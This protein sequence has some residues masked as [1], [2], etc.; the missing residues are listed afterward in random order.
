MA[1]KTL[2]NAAGSSRRNNFDF[3]RFAAASFV[4]ISHSFALAGSY[5]EPKIGTT[6]LGTLGVN[7]FFIISGYLI[8][9]SWE[10]HPRVSA[11]IGKRLLRIVP[12][13]VGATLFV[14]LI[15]GPIFT[16]L[17][18]DQYFKHQSTTSYLGNIS[19]FTLQYHLPGVW[20]NNAF[21][22]NTNGPLWTLP[23]EFVA[24]LC[25]AIGGFVGILKNRF[26]F[27]PS[28]LG[29]VGCTF[30]LFKLLEG[31]GLRILSIELFFLVTNISFF[32]IG[33]LL[34]AHRE[35][36]IYSDKLALVALI[37]FVLSPLSPGQFYLRLLTL[38][39]LVIYLACIKTKHMYKFAKY[40]DLSY[41]MY[42]YAWPVQQSIFALQG[43]NMNPIKMTILAFPIIILLS[44]LSWHLIEKRFIKLKHH[45]DRSRYPVI[46]GR[47]G[48]DRVPR[49]SL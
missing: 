43:T 17:P 28:V 7:I 38:P 44:Y 6:T 27:I 47:R 39:Y 30:I 3:I 22:E 11:F 45:F 12:G 31:T 16:S 36:V 46:E 20:E 13:L 48:L 49:P 10:L 35:K 14:L 26:R 18:L 8:T 32:A 25:V 24:Y 21:P 19:I 42:I 29:V 2:S 37:I 34:Y 41:G 4:I 9:Q 5:A 1:V 33:S 23:L 40:G 15:V